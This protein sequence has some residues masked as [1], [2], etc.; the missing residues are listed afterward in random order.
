MSFIFGNGA[1]ATLKIGMN[2]AHNDWLELAI[3]N[4]VIGLILYVWYYIALFIDYRKIKK[5]NRSY[6]NVILMTIVILFATSLFSMSYASVDIAMAIALG[7]ILA[8]VYTTKD[9]NSMLYR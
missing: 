7:F 5:V 1:N 4:G 3:N 6:A 8:Q 9:E 2:Y